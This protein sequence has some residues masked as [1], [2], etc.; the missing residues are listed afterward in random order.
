MHQYQKKSHGNSN[1]R[2]PIFGHEKNAVMYYVRNVCKKL[3]YLIRVSTYM[4][5]TKLCSWNVIWMKN[6]IHQDIYVS[7]TSLLTHTVAQPTNWR[8]LPKIFSQLVIFVIE[9]AFTWVWG[10]KHRA[11]FQKMNYFKKWSYQKMVL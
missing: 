6:H 8:F 11:K 5:L 10:D 2:F 1:M 4:N 3:L 7:M 9:L